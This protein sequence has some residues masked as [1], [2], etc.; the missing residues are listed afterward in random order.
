MQIGTPPIEATGFRYGNLRQVTTIELVLTCHEALAVVQ[1]RRRRR[2]A[3]QGEVALR[4]RFCFASECRA[5]FFLCPRCDHGQRYCSLAC[6]QQSRRQ[7]RRSANRRHQQSLEGRL[8][9]RD[10][11]RQYRERHCRARVTDQGSILITG[12]ASSSYEA[13]ETTSPEPAKTLAASR[14]PRWP[15]NRLGVRLCCRVCGRVGRFID[16]FPL[17]PRRR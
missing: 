3:V 12:S 9:H 5:L 7:Q 10:R 11:Q 1:R 14:Y 15:E 4:Q 2:M 17:I 8:D 6:R 13:A 16:P